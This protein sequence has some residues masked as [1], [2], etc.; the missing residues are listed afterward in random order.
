MALA[1]EPSAK[2]ACFLLPAPILKKP[3]KN[4]LIEAALK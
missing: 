1:A 4:G 2:N 3:A